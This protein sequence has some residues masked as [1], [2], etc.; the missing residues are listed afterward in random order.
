M[1]ITDSSLIKTA[2]SSTGSSSAKPAGAN[3]PEKASGPE[4]GFA[5]T[6]ENAIDRVNHDMNSAGSMIKK[7]A[8]GADVDIADTMIAISKADISFRMMLQV[9]NKA[10]SAYEEV[11][12][13]Q[14]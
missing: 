13:M 6:L 8:S 5:E 12:R 1:N 14:V 10:L 11:M 3:E 9:R 4:K 7:M 2:V